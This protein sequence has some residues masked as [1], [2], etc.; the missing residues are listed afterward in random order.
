[1]AH[2]KHHQPRRVPWNDDDD[3]D[4]ENN[5]DDDDDGDDDDDDARYFI[6]EHV[7]MCFD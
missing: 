7:A 1:M 5:D 3:D 4:D 6:R 2:I